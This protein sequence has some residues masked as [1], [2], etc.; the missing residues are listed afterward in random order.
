M[1]KSAFAANSQAKLCALALIADLAGLPAPQP[2]LLNTCYSLVSPSQAISVS[3][4]Y[5]LAGDRLSALS[6]GS[7]PVTGDDALRE[8]EAVD[9]THWYR[10]ILADSFGQ[11]A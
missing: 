10:S 6:E 5:G 1:P 7:S 3:G 8:R 2:T 4:V 11:R 9:A